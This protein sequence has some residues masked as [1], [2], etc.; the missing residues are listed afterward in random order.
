MAKQDVASKL[1]DSKD[2]IKV[3]YDFGDNLAESVKLF[4]E[5]VVHSRAKAALV[6]DLQALVRRMIK[7]GKKSDEIT[8]AVAK[9]KPDT[10]VVVHKTAA[11]KVQEGVKQLTKEERLALL[12]QLQAIKD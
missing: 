1:K 6:I 11:E 5:E 7:A 2:V 8:A 9:W 10:R 12:K 4:G 3:Q